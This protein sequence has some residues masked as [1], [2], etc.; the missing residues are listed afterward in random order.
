M[1]H[2]YG[3]FP[4]SF[5]FLS[6][7]GVKFEQGG[8][9]TTHEQ[10]NCRYSCCGPG[11]VTRSAFLR[12]AFTWGF[13][14]GVRLLL[15]LLM[16]EPF[17]NPPKRDLMIVKKIGCTGLLLFAPERFPDISSSVCGERPPWQHR[18]SIGF[19]TEPAQSAA[20]SSC[21]VSIRD[22]GILWF[23]TYCTWAHSEPW[24][25][26]QGP[27]LGVISGTES[28]CVSENS[29]WRLGISFKNRGFSTAC[30][31][32]FSCVLQVLCQLL[33][34]RTFPKKATVSQ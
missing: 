2:R 23:P 3:V 13:A 21:S 20:F 17:S 29:Q 14:L 6:D 12:A 25:N 1:C 7:Q 5:L 26:R 33:G 27:V 16:P 22:H 10:Q 4:A 34:I 28:F 18:Q 8:A 24:N 9:T 32:I 30:N 11:E 15:P 19:S 31:L